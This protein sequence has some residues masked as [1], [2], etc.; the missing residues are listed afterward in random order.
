[1]QKVKLP[2]T[3]VHPRVLTMYTL[4]QML[5]LRIYF[6]NGRD[7]FEAGKI[8]TVAGSPVDNWLLFRTVPIQIDRNMGIIHVAVIDFW[9]VRCF[10]PLVFPQAL[11][12]SCGEFFVANLTLEGVW[13]DGQSEA[14]HT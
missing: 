10:Y 4:E 14:A 3:A 9:A 6:G 11:P 1:M 5:G 12:I 2:E 7:W 13:K 8:E